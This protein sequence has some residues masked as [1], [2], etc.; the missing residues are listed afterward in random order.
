MDKQEFLSKYPKQEEKLLIANVLDKLQ[1]MQAKNEVQTTQF[2][3][4]HE[5][6]IVQKLCKA[7]QVENASLE[8]G[9]EKAERKVLLLYPDKLSTVFQNQKN[10]KL[11][12]QLAV[13]SITL[14]NELIGKYQHRN[15]LSAIIKLGM[16]RE[17]VGDILVRENGADILV[18]KEVAS[19]L[20]DDLR[21]L[22]R[23]QKA[24]IVIRPIAELQLVENKK[25][26]ICILVPQLRVDC[27]ISELL[28]LS[29][30]K[31]TEM[32]EQERIFVNYE[33]KTKASFL[34]KEND[35][36]TIRGKGKYQ[37]GKMVGESSKGKMRLEVEKYI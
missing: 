36:L 35:I 18:K 23:F 19:Y 26:S 28:H 27:V 3:D 16:N 10:K 4:G 5:Q 17:K 34:L 31:T 2:L 37:I 13:I 1:F 8:G 22:T 12:Q 29:R 21:K 30:S 33:L 15:Y 25:E 11:N 20:Q 9:Y 24:E 14:P 32:I 6:N 7:F